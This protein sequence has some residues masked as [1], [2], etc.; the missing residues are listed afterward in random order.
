MLEAASFDQGMALAHG[1]DYDV[2]LLDLA[3]PGG[4]GLD[5]LA[6]LRSAR[7][8]VPV[9]ILTARGAESDRVRGLRGGADDYL[10]KPF[11]SDE[12]A[13]RVEALL[14]RGGVKPRAI[15]GPLQLG[16]VEVDVTRQRA[17]WPAGGAELTAQE[18]ALLQLLAERREAV[19]SRTELHALLWPGQPV[20]L[21][22]RALDMAVR[23]LREK[24]GPAASS[25][26]TVR[27]VGLRL[28]LSEEN[29]EEV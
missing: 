19:V 8:V 28:D 11:G 13:A 27:G 22:S 21:H 17:S 26:V 14:R 18:V 1:A 12:L 2:L 7:N 25:V 6:S 5:I 10:V 23:R 20:D 9:L 16:M 4:D 24:L 29:G 3:L 15:A